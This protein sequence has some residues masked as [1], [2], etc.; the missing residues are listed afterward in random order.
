MTKFNTVYIGLGSN[1]GKRLDYIKKA[2]DLISELNSTSI[3][4]ISNI[5]ESEPY[6]NVDQPKFLNC[7]LKLN[8]TIEPLD[9]LIKLKNIEKN[10]GRKKTKKW[11]PRVIDIDILLYNNLTMDSLELKIPHPDLLNR[12][13]VIKPLLELDKNIV[14]P[15]KNKKIS[16]LVKDKQLGGKAQF[17]TKLND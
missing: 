11:S 2:I 6:G 7:V 12:D 3:D 13:F 9:L 17:Y 14:H 10:M 4:A 8:T 1:L 5:Y 15:V 16:E